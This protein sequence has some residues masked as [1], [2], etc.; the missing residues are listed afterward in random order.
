M[1]Y[2]V[3]SFFYTPCRFLYTFFQKDFL[4]QRNFVTLKNTNNMNMNDKQMSYE[5]P[6]VEVIE[7]EIEKGFA[8]SIETGSLDGFDSAI[9]NTDWL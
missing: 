9:G 8:T 6:Q 7:V 3:Y 2:T 5:S 4:F 1:W